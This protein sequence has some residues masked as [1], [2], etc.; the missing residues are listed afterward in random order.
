MAA[1]EL[2]R[3]VT[4]LPA[5]LAFWLGCARG[6]NPLRTV[7]ECLW[8]RQTHWALS[9]CQTQTDLSKL[10]PFSPSSLP[11]GVALQVGHGCKQQERHGACHSQSHKVCLQEDMNACHLSHKALL[12]LQWPHGLSLGSHPGCAANAI[13]LCCKW[14]ES[15]PSIKFTC[16]YAN[17]L[18]SLLVRECSPPSHNS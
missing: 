18:G 16:T 1:I 12:D 5:H 14:H 11:L 13:A 7:T 9:G 3:L 10:Q 8:L 6:I 2:P 4:L 17:H 15:P